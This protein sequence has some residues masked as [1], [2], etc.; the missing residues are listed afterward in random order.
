MAIKNF[1]SLETGECIFAE[2]LYKKYKD[3]LDLY[4]PLKDIG[5]DLIAVKKGA[6]KG[7]VSFQVKESRYYEKKAEKKSSTWHQETKKKIN[8]SRG[9]VDFWVFLIYLPGYLAGTNKKNKF[10]KYFIIIPTGELLEKV[11][12]KTP[13][14]NGKYH[15]Y[16]R[17]EADNKEVTDVRENEKT[18]ENNRGAFD[19]S[20][21]LNAW[22]FI[23]RKI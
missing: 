15:F 19:Y 14:K 8:R 22:Q 20:K 23:E 2:E 3:K 10:E 21:Y 6:H 13:D 4:F 7:M 5:V 18:Q 11:K 1:W 9:R 17:I 16:F 12:F